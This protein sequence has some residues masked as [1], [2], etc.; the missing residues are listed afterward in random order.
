VSVIVLR[1]GTH[2]TVQDLGRGGLRHLGVV[3]GGAMDTVSHR[4]ANALVGNRSDEASLEIA[5]SGPDL[6]ITQDALV[7]LYGARFAARLDGKPLPMAR[8]VLVRAGARLRIGRAEDGFFGYLAIAGG[9]DVP[10]VLGSRSTYVPGGFGGWQGKAVARD[11]SLPLVAGVADLSVRRFERVS[12]RGTALGARGQSVTWFAP[13]VMATIGDPPVV[14]AI[15]GLHHEL[16]KPAARVAFFSERWRV[17]LDSNRMGLRLSGQSPLPL[18]QATEILSQPTCRGTVQ[19]PASGQPIVLAADHQ[20]TGGY[21]KIAEVIAA[22]AP[23]LAH[24]PPG[25]ELRFAPVTLEEA[26]A[27][28]AI[29]AE[30]IDVLIERILWEFGDD[31]D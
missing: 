30:R 19:V 14:R 8:P 15:P 16:F 22:D 28:R 29:L 6:L 13:N 3:P 21:P 18:V 5:L 11:A 31:V 26:D 25:Q 7:A 17:G 27:A 2:A 4:I 9:F 20:S 10:P 1:P 12:R 24:V 23:R